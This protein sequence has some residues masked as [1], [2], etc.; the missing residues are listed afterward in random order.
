MAFVST[1]LPTPGTSSI[2]TCPRQITA[3]S[4]RCTAS[5]LPT[6]TC[7]TFAMT[8]CAA[9]LMSATDK[10]GRSS[11]FTPVRGL[12]NWRT[13]SC[14]HQAATCRPHSFLNT[15]STHWRVIS[16]GIATHA[17]CNCVI[18]EGRS[19]IDHYPQFSV[20]LVVGVK[21][22]G[23]PMHS[24]PTGERLLCSSPFV[25]SLT[26]R[27]GYPLRMFRGGHKCIRILWATSQPAPE[28]VSPR[29]LRR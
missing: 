9:S 16:P 23:I 28:L 24:P 25:Q 10:V 18:H 12:C 17:T 2:S 6:M 27:R 14:V 22:L 29:R 19:L 20:K 3:M 7:S 5:C 4:V 21:S 26:N 8:R 11:N 15:R 13:L 1:V